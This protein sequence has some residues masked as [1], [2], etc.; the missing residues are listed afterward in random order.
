MRAFAGKNLRSRTASARSATGNYN[1]FAFEPPGRHV[2]APAMWT[3]V[4][5]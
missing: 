1:F 5:Y 4:F 3:V 2:Y